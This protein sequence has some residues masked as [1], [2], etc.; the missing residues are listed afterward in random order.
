MDEN[1]DINLEDKA[2]DAEVKEEKDVKNV[3]DT[4]D[5]DAEKDIPAD[6][7]EEILEVVLSDDED[8]E[9]SDPETPVGG[10]DADIYELSGLTEA[11]RK[12]KMIFDKITTGIL[13]ALLA[14]PILILGYIF[15]WFLTK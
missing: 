1:K 5:T 7:P 4:P 10:S 11:Q 15:L 8:A 2:D 12:R 14:S 6:A 13:I 3:S 9:A